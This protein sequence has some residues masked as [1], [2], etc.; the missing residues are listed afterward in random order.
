MKRYLTY[1]LIAVIFP[2]ALFMPSVTLGSDQAEPDA[3]FTRLRKTIELNADGS[4]K[5]SVEKVIRINS[6]YAFHRE[7]GETFIVYDPVYEQVNIKECYTETPGGKK[8]VTPPNAFNELLPSFAAN[9]PAFSHLRE[10]VITHTALEIGAV[11]H[12]KYE[13]I[14][15]PKPIRGIYGMEVFTQAEKVVDYQ[16]TLK[17]PSDKVLHH[18]VL[19]VETNPVVDKAGGLTTYTWSLKDLPGHHSEVLEPPMQSGLPCIVFSTLGSVNEML[20]SLAGPS[21]APPE[22]PQGARDAIARI[23]GASQGTVEMALKI[24]ELVVNEINTYRI[25]FGSDRYAARPPNQVWQANGGTPFEKLWLMMALLGEAGIRAVPVVAIPA[26]I[27]DESIGVPATIEALLIQV[28]VPGNG[29]FY[30]SPDRI[31]TID[32]V[33]GMAGR[34]FLSLEAQPQRFYPPRQNMA[35][36][37]LLKADLELAVG[38][39]KGKVVLTLKNGFNPYYSLLRQKGEFR[40]VFTTAEWNK[41]IRKVELTRCT[42]QESILEITID[43]FKLPAGYDNIIVFDLPHLAPGFS[44]FQPE[45]PPLTRKLP[46]HLPLPVSESYEITFTNRE[47][48]NLSFTGSEANLKNA[49][50]TFEKSRSNKGKESSMRQAL[51]LKSNCDTEEYRGFLKLYQQWVNPSNWKVVITK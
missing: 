31:N 25:P 37:S 8:V 21:S 50:G 2:A 46:L 48:S 14:A 27:L 43:A 4:T 36:V 47:G 51:I 49:A 16:F 23:A 41:A 17:V 18:R 29:T 30:L 38:Q 28:E 22:L 20:A 42:P 24:Q 13:I 11:I 9:S 19:N 12:L 26:Q 39:V 15:K 35:G 3:V 32:P 34:V 10:M 1:I 44:Q 7:Y 40:E 45:Q 6:Y 5:L 33:D